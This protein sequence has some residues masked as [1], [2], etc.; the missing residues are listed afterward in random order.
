LL[1][2]GVEGVEVGVND[3]AIHNQIIREWVRA[4]A[5]LKWHKHGSSEAPAAA[6]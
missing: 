6:V 2:G 5:T 4:D 3:G 1:D